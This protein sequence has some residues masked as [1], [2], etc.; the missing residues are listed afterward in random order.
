MTDG[1]M[2]PVPAPGQRVTGRLLNRLWKVNARHALYHKDGTFFEVLVR[3]P[4]ALF[5]WSGYV[6][7]ETVSQ[8]ERAI[9]VTEKSNIP[10]GIASLPMYVRVRQ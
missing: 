7:F 10:E 1:P 5:D 4:G 9:R 2:L 6:L 3:F 8:Y